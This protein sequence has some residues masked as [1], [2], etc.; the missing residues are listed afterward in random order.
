M[1]ATTTRSKTVDDRL[2]KHDQVI[3]QLQVD[4]QAIFTQLHDVNFNIDARFS[5]L[6]AELQQQ[7][8]Q[9][10]SSSM[11]NRAEYEGSRGQNTMNLKP[12][13]ID[14]PRFEGGDPQGWIFKI[15]QYFDFHNASEEQR[16]KVAPLYFDGEALAWY[17]WCQHNNKIGSLK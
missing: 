7:R 17:Q 5:T 9:D 16:L 8:G 12:L 11:Q 3:Q 1:A 4:V 13:R 2:E 14:V 6:M 15:Q 10:A